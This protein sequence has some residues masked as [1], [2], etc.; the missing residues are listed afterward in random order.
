MPQVS[1]DQVRLYWK[2]MQKQYRFKVVDKDDAGEMQLIGWALDTM[3]IQDQDYF[4]HNYT[5]TVG[6]KIYI[7]FE[8]GVG[9]Q[10]QLVGQIMTC[11]HECQHIVQSRRDPMYEIKYLTSDAARTLYEVDAYQANMEIHWW[12]YQKTLNPT[13]L[14]NTLKGYSIDAPNRRVAKKRFISANK[15]IEYGGVTTGTAI[16]T[17]RWCNRNLKPARSRTVRVIKV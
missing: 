15:M 11:A 8:V 3:G 12:W 9:T 17:I 7:P 2:Y 6:S 4:L 1:G 13:I 10:K 16:K 5:T 14:V